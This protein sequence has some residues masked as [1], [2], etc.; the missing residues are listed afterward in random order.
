LFPGFT[1]QRAEGCFRSRFEETLLIHIGTREPLQVIET[2]HN[3]RCFLKQEG[4]GLSHNGIY[5]R[6][7]EWSDDNLILQSFGF[8]APHPLNHTP[9]SPILGTIAMGFHNRNSAIRFRELEAAPYRHIP[10]GTVVEHAVVPWLENPI[11]VI[12]SKPSDKPPDPLSW[13]RVR[14]L[15]YFIP[16]N[17]ET[18]MLECDTILEE[19]HIRVHDFYRGVFDNRNAPRGT[20]IASGDDCEIE[21]MVIAWADLTDQWE[22]SGLGERYSFWKDVLWPCKSVRIKTQEWEGGGPGLSGTWFTVRSMDPDQLLDEISE[23]FQILIER[24]NKDQAR[25]PRQDPTKPVSGRSSRSKED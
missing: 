24:D 25:S 22:E 2:A 18:P 20:L 19:M 8:V 7:R 16:R 10:G 9:Q 5:Q 14:T 21:G 13:G 4:I 23:W 1:I 15:W 17:H 3:L 6:V 11:G 12:V